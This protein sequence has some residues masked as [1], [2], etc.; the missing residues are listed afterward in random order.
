MQVIAIAKGYD[1]VTVRNP[2]EEFTMPDTVFDKRP[3]LD[4]KG[5]STGINYED[6]SWFRKKTDHRE[7]AVAARAVALAAREKADAAPGDK[8]LGRIA[9]AADAKAKSLEAQADKADGE[10]D[11]A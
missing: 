4:E 10:G 5:K 11:L 1:G 8:N 9:D 3:K 2:G 6:P 7:R